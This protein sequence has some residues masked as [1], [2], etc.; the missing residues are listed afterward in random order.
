M[1]YIVW[2]E[3]DGGQ[4]FCNKEDAIRYAKETGGTIETVTEIT[5]DRWWR[6]DGF[7]TMEEAKQFKAN[8][9]YICWEERTPK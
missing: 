7:E 6:V 8:G 3:K 4:Q 9:G 1:F 5:S 2:T